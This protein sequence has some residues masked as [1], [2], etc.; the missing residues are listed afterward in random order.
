MQEPMF[1]VHVLNEIGMAKAR[2]LQKD[3]EALE[4]SITERGSTWDAKE[5]VAGRELALARTHLEIS[6]FYAKRAMAMQPG[7][8]DPAT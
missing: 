8:H 4:R 3:Y 2:E 7:N 6:S 5:N 1:D